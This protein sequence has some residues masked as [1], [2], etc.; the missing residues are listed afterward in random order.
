MGTRTYPLRLLPETLLTSI[1]L[2]LIEAYPEMAMPLAMSATTEVARTDVGVSEKVL[3]KRRRERYVIY[4]DR[5][6]GADDDDSGSC[7]LPQDWGHSATDGVLEAAG[8]RKRTRPTPVTKT[9]EKIN[10]KS[11]AVGCGA[12][13]LASTTARGV[14]HRSLLGPSVPQ[15]SVGALVHGQPSWT[16]E[17]EEEETRHDAGSSTLEPQHPAISEDIHAIPRTLTAWQQLL[18]Q[19]TQADMERGTVNIIKCRMCPDE[20]FKTWA[21]FARHCRDCEEHPAK[22]KCCDRCGIYFG[23]QD[24]MKRHKESV[25]KAC[26]ATTPAEAAWRKHKAEQL[27]ADFQTRVE[28]CMRTGEELGR[29]F[30]AIAREELPSRSKKVFLSKKTKSQGNSSQDSGSR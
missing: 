19:T 1:S 28:Y 3:G 11:E 16:E 20:P 7:E 24:S 18:L 5:S 27:L 10:G 6:A 13:R 22:I 29:T 26:C 21:C 14:Y 17:R 30:A 9:Q 4:L 25:T 23:R 8:S 12:G 15:G 2:S